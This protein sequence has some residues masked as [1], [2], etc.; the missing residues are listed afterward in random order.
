MK[1]SKIDFILGLIALILAILFLVA[2]AHDWLMGCGEPY[3]T[4][5]GLQE[6]DNSGCIF[7][8]AGK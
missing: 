5:Q 1:E 2:F 7:Y 6:P 3:Y 8:G 4:A